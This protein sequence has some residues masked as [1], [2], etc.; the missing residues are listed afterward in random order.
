MGGAEVGRLKCN[1]EALFVILWV[2]G[3]SLRT[4][5]S[6]KGS[7]L[8]NFQVFPGCFTS[9]GLEPLVPSAAL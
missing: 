5:N 3:G 8:F 9:S 2:G 4:E 1:Y 6:G 7:V